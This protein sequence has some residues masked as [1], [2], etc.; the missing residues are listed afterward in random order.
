[1]NPDSPENTVYQ[2]QTDQ[3][4]QT[5]FG[6][7]DLAD[8]RLNTRLAS[9]FQSF[10]SSP[11]ASIP[12]ATSHWAKT[13]A[14]YRFLNNVKVTHEKILMP[15][16]KATC[17]RISREKIVLAVQD[18]T[19][20]DYT[21]L[22][23]TEGLGNIATEKHSQ[24]MLVHSTLAFTPERV[25]LGLIHQQ[26]WIRSPEEYG[27]KHTRY[28]RA[29]S[30]KESYKWLVSLNAT[31]KA[32]K[33]SPGTLLINVGDREADIYE[34][35]L[36]ASTCAS[37][38]IVRAAWDRRVDHPEEHLWAYM[39]AQPPAATLQ[40]NIP[41]KGKNPERNAKI[42]LRFAPV[43]I[44]SPRNNKSTVP[45]V[46]AYA[47]YVKELSPPKNT[48][49]LSWLLLTTMEVDSLETAIKVV[50][51]Y[52][53][54]FSIELFHKVLKSGCKIERRQLKTI[55]ALVRCLAI[56]SIVAWR[57]MFLT[58][59]G[60]IVPEIPC[61]VLL[62]DHEWKSLHCYIFKTKEPPATPP[63]LGEAVRLVARLGGFLARKN[64]G[65]PGVQLLWRGMKVLSVISI[66][67]IAFGPESNLARG[68]SQI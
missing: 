65:H 6:S 15:H 10:C 50:E 44:R 23:E 29:I 2:Q 19:T 52:A 14:A 34:L 63:S 5:E 11:G 43:Q 49:P 47:V 42:E 36:H 41:R 68:A 22:H 17:S 35:L 45:V 40:V 62:E 3:W 46:S 57:I 4:I 25:P 32:Q 38:L 66:A 30:D 61:T 67:W 1:M 12:Q 33:E 54:R 48:E 27:K 39:E 51:Y 56:Y 7:L 60:R 21:H 28:N 20:L 8:G 13:K 58:M 64:D 9:L 59:L 37:K 31:E 18:T 26:S 16:Q 53:A 24:G 55:D